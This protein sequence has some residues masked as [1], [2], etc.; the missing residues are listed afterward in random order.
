MDDMNPNTSIKT[1]KLLAAARSLES[2]QSG[3]LLGL[4]SGTTVACLIP[5]LGQKVGAGLSITVVVTSTT[6]GKLARAAG[7]QVINFDGSI[8]V[9]LTIDGAD[10]ITETLDL[11]KGGG[12]ALLHEKI[13]AAGS[14]KEIIIAHA[15]KLVKVLGAAPLPVE[16]IKFGWHRVAEQLSLLSST[17]RLRTDTNGTPFITDEGNYILDCQFKQIA[18][19]ASLAERLDHIVGVVEHGLFIGLAS[20]AIIGS[21]T[22]TRVITR[23]T[24]IMQPPRCA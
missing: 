23:S 20:E 22:T 6:T 21:G 16:V 2:V 12:G 14:K 19:P 5:L 13:V 9:D 10:E 7:I 18:D 8:K 11:I 17:P 4:G 3:M 24:T 1:E 15:S